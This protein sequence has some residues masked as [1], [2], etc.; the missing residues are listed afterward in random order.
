M[1]IFGGGKVVC[2]INYRKQ[3]QK[4]QKQWKTWKI[5]VNSF[6]PPG[7]LLS[8]I[9]PEATYVFHGSSEAIS[10]STHRTTRPFLR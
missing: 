3:A 1:G 9:N 8:S 4:Y 2:I 5:S 7:H 6:I 10:E